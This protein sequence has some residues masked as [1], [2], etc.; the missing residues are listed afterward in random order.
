MLFYRP[1]EEITPEPAAE[2]PGCNVAPPETVQ[3]G[4]ADAEPADS[5]DDVC[6][7]RR[8]PVFT[9]KGHRG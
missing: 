7:L 6:V 3:E 4:P 2:T 1:R 9:I 5:A 8:G